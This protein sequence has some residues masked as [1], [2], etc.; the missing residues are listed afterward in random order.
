V[1]LERNLRRAPRNDEREPHGARV[2]A[3]PRVHVVAH[4]LPERRALDLDGDERVDG[5]ALDVPE[6]RASG[7]DAQTRGLDSAPELVRVAAGEVRAEEREGVRPGVPGDHLDER[8]L[9]R[10]GGERGGHDEADGTPLRH[11][12]GHV[13][14]R[15]S[16]RSGKNMSAI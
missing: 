10:L 8:G 9:R 7:R 6:V 1:A 11:D 2:V 13:R 3:D 14:E 16:A 5:G 15:A 4:A 12:A